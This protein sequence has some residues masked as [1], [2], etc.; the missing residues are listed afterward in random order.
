MSMIPKYAFRSQVLEGC[1][2]RVPDWLSDPRVLRRLESASLPHEVRVVNDTP[3]MC[4]AGF[5][6]EAPAW[7]K[8]EAIWEKAK[9]EVDPKKAKDY[10]AVVTTVYKNMG[11]RVGSRVQPWVVSPGGTRFAGQDWWKGKEYPKL[12]GIHI[13]KCPEC[14]SSLDWDNQNFLCPKC[15]WMGKRRDLPE[16][17][18]KI[19]HSLLGSIF[20]P[21]EPE[22]VGYG[23]GLGRGRGKNRSW[24]NNRGRGRGVGMPGGMRRNRNPDP[25]PDYEG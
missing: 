14:G 2:V 5:I 17:T 24:P 1:E 9:K 20:P 10:W 21:D 23:R 19:G 4:V 15:G 13:P 3:L 22:E 8:D 6:V 12:D 7:V 11:G 16:D 18:G 25:C